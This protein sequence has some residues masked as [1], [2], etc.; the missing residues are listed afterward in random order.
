MKLDYFFKPLGVAVVGA[1]NDQEKIGRQVL[2]NIINSGYRGQIYP[3]NLEEK[4]IAGLLAF[5][6]LDKIPTKKFSSVLVVIA[7]PA[8]FVVAEIEKCGRLGI[9]NII[10]IS[11]GFKEI[12]A[13]GLIREQEVLALADKYHLNI[14]GPNCL[15]FINNVS[16]LNASFGSTGSASGRIALLSQ[17]GAIGSAV[18]DWLKG[19]NLN[20]GYFISLGN[21]MVLDENDFLP[22]LAADKNTE[23]IIIYLEDIKDGQKFMELVSRISAKK[24]VIVLKAGMSERG[25][26]IAKSHTG[27]LAGGSAAVKAG[28]ERSGAVIAE[29]L[30]DLFGILL[31]LQAKA[32]RNGVSNSLQILTNAGGLAVLSADEVSR[33][34]LVLSDSHDI[35][36]DAD[37]IR[38]EESLSKL[39]KQPSLDSILVLL[40]PQTSTE[41][42]KTAE[43]IVKLSKKYPKRL[44]LVSFLGGEAVQKA[45]ELMF[46]SDLPIFDYPEQALR[47]IKKL[48]GWK[49]I[50]KEL[51]PFKKSTATPKSTSLDYLSLFK[52]LKQYRI[53]VVKTIRYGSNDPISYPVVLKAVG[54]D[55][56]HKT[57]KKAVILNLKNRLELEKAAAGVYRSNK[58]IMQNEQNYLIV[59]PQI[60][61]SLEII[62]GFKRDRS[63]GPILLIGLGGIY[64]EIFKEFKLTVADLNQKKANE[65]ISSLPFYPILAGAR[66]KKKY[67]IEQLVDVLISFS[68]LA[69][70][71]PEIAEFDINPLF[72]KEKESLAGDVR[73]I[74]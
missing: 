70:E 51:T 15:G 26:E 65:L 64:A 35:Y 12:G 36:G 33:Q 39:L 62:L 59:Q 50:N 61:D 3:I 17:S 55:F 53:P 1:S 5:S 32:T 46:E 49:V 6:S 37:A 60:T 28:L 16:R 27:A 67:N 25:S 41:P 22:Y 10:I 52:L 47:A 21:K 43:A 42:L 38:Y 40:T 73:A 57:D 72:I 18:S 24:P 14:L 66:G 9:K 68:R 7:I 74:I 48:S 13:D 54:P 30:E 31:L 44:I 20:L 58:R 4:K 23:A 71:H 69:A 29:S 63:F 11:S 56:L 34:G 2:D 19:R 8:K 45:V